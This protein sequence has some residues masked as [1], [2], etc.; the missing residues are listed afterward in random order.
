MTGPEHDKF[1]EYH[2]EGTFYTRPCTCEYLAKVRADERQKHLDRTQH[3]RDRIERLIAKANGWR[4][5]N[6][7]LRKELK[8]VQET[9]QSSDK[10]DELRDR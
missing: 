2:G 9:V 4:D 8:S 1:C 10:L 5:E 7:E 3:L 6:V